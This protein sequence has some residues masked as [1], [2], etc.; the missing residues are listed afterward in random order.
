[1]KNSARV[2]TATSTIPP[3]ISRYVGDADDDQAA[4]LRAVRVGMSD[5]LARAIDDAN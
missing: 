5:C 1:M 4:V 3:T 2:R